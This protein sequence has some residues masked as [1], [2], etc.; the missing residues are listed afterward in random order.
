MLMCITY[1]HLVAIATMTTQDPR[2]PV[3]EA[4][5]K[6][7]SQ[8]HLP[9]LLTGEHVPVMFTDLASRFSLAPGYAP[10]AQPEFM[11]IH[12]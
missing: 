9:K 3:G 6:L 8:E 1:H 5:I 10:Y 7:N 12:P 2:A 4:T 11:K